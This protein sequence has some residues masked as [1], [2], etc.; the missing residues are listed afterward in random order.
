VV[1]VIPGFPTNRV[2][3]GLPAIADLVERLA[4]EVPLTLIA[5]HHP[6]ARVQYRLHGARV[7]PLALPSGTGVAGRARVLAHGVAEL[8][9]QRRAAHV[10]VIHAIWADEPGAIA[11]LAAPLVRARAVVS[12]M[13]G[14]LVALPD[15]GYGAALGRGGRWTARLALRRA[16][17][18]TVGSTYLAD[19]ARATRARTQPELCPLGVDIDAFR[20][21]NVTLQERQAAQ[22]VLLVGSLEPVK[23]PLAAVRVFASVAITRP[24]VR[25][26]LCGMG[27]L[28]SPVRQ[29]AAELGVADRVEIRG[30]VPR[31]ELPSLHA[32][33]AALM[34]TSRHE[35]QHVAAIEAAASGVPVVG[36]A[37]GALPDLGAG[38]LVVPRGD[39]A[40]LARALARILDDPAEA[41]SI[42]AAGRAAAVAGYDVRRTTERFLDIYER[43]ARRA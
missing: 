11:V 17:A 21:G 5:L 22:R 10:D 13:G 25:L 26:V 39:E 40:A 32:G 30:H 9:R 7:V 8:V 34:V 1:A 37:V 38:A 27:S 6:L 33:A 19:M 20:P 18:L 35:G 14:E 3:P 42:S 41:V 23:D 43:L 4:A 36:Y 29:M 28:E 2:E 12:I 16:D 24:Q 31:D 15:I